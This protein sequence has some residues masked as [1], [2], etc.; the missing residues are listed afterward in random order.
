MIDE[1]IEKIRNG[2]EPCCCELIRY[3]IIQNGEEK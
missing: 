3:E 2:E 1:M